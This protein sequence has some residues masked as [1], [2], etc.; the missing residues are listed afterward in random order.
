MGVMTKSGN[1]R[2]LWHQIKKGATY[3]APKGYILKYINKS[4]ERLV[5]SRHLPQQYVADVEGKD[6]I[7]KLNPDNEIDGRVILN[8]KT[9]LWDEG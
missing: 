8:P 3:M 6:V 9:T 5:M 1:H 4:G 2:I 7:C